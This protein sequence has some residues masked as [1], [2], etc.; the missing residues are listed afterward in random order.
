MLA[1]LN[2]HISERIEERNRIKERLRTSAGRRRWQE[3][4][5]VA[6]TRVTEAM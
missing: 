6:K 1:Y 5:E 2:L 3:Q 4:M